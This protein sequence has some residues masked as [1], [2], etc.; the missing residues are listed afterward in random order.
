MFR[1]LKATAGLV[2]AIALA[3]AAYAQTPT[4][5]EEARAIAKEAYVYAYA[6]ITSYGT[7][8][9]QATLPDAPEYVGGFN[10]FRHYSES[11]TPDN[12][13]LVTPNNDTPYSWAWLDLR[14]EP[15][16]LSVPKVPKDRY[17]VM[18]L[19][20][21]F[22]YNFGYVGVRSTGFGAGNY[23]I[24][25]PNWRGEKPKGIAKV[26]QA[27]TEIIGILGR[28][29]LDG[30]SDV[31]NVKA[32]QAKYR[33]TPLST[34]LMK[35]APPAA[36]AITFPPY[37]AAKAASHD[38]IGYINFLL[39][40]AQPTVPS[41]MDLMARFAK[42]GI[43]PGKPWDAAKIDPAELAAIDQG[44][45]DAK[46][47]MAQVAKTTL[48]SNGLFGTREF[49][50]NDYMKRAM[51][52]E[53]GLYGNSLEEAWY[54]GF[55]GDGTKQTMLHFP[56]GQLPPA[57][58]FWSLTLYTLPDRFLYANPLKR[59]SIGDRTKDLVYGEDKSLTI[60]LGHTS[61]GKGKESNWL[62][63]P[64]GKYSLVG[65]VYGP[66]KAAMDGTWKLPKPEEVK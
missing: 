45:E 20:D 42:I 63:T 57:K 48:S 3:P 66:E 9:K 6:P 26:I 65:R 47:E 36:P 62:P 10:T 16:V 2:L 38:F 32:I 28:T 35:P 4:T 46:A 43:E 23:L 50:K 17:Y 31:K 25:G 49:L 18:Q 60:Y 34:F 54:G 53:K 39:Q 40:F 8:S 27:E 41:E 44:V 37:D 13:D 11:F 15:I 51:G 64:D 7:W 24:A 61:P 5:P 29:S 33:L 55:V 22:T 52:A 30:P 12:K 56:P 19:I 58:F 14:A 59:Y 1:E 21:L